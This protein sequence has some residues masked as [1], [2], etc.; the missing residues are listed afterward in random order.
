M[1]M[2]ALKTRVGNATVHLAISTKWRAG[3]KTRRQSLQ[4]ALEN[5][6]IRGFHSLSHTN[7]MGGFATATQP[8]GFDLEAISRQ[9][10]DRA[11][12]R[13]ATPK[14]LKM[15]DDQA[16]I[17]WVMKEA[18][19]KALRGEHQPKTIPGIT[20]TAIKKKI[21]IA[22]KKSAKEWS[23]SFKASN[24]SSL[25]HFGRGR[26]LTV[27]RTIVGIAVAHT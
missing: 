24:S 25:R 13:I 21:K 23:F 11:T 16:I 1:A 22:K 8:V 15:C 3:S 19:F 20:I 2:T 14:E 5:D 27:G 12:G 4:K 7:H 17:I 18:A 26:C 10:S 6:D 9:V